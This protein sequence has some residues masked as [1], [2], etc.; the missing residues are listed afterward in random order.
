MTARRHQTLVPKVV[1]AAC[2]SKNLGKAKLY[3]PKLSTTQQPSIVQR[4]LDNKIDPR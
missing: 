1:L 3:Y 4:C 2:N